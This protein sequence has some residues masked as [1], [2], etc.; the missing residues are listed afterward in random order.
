MG[1]PIRIDENIYNEA[2]KV[3]AA[4][5]R[6]IPNQIEYWAKLGKCALDN[7]DLPIEFIKDVLLSKLQDKSLAEP[8]QFESEG[9]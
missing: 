1:I 7:P 4:E 2:K 8:F 3:A 5:F 6:S 9:E